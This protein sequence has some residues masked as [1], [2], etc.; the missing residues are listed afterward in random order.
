MNSYIAFGLKIGTP[1][2]LCLNL[3]A[4]T[5]SLYTRGNLYVHWGLG[6]S[7]PNPNFEALPEKLGRVQ[8]GYLQKGLGVFV[9]WVGRFWLK[10]K[11]NLYIEPLPNC[12][13]TQVALYL[14]G[15]VLV[16]RLRLEPILSFHGSAVQ[17]PNGVL[18]ILGNQGAGKS[19]TATALAQAG[20]PLLC[21]DVIPL[22]SESSPPMVLPGIARPKL[23][24][25][26]YE[27]LV[28]DPSKAQHLWD[29]ID[30]Y[31]VSVNSTFEPGSLDR[32]VILEL[33]AK[34]DQPQ[35]VS[36]TGLA[37]L[38]ALQPHLQTL[39]GLDKP[40]LQLQSLMK[41]GG[42]IQVDRLIRPKGVESLST[43]TQLLENVLMEFEKTVDRR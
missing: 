3:P 34:V 39:G 37:K 7:L 6:D 16:F 15:L 24:P 32:I 21:D 36:L 31:Q 23:L 19:T 38:Q 13:L 1:E 10:D 33:G 26:A 14:V 42:Q 30:K 11:E 22:L 8:Y 35:F 28:G 2:N 41:L 27:A 12:D 18:M 4:F 20:F 40:D 25:D 5:D 17:G 29:G 43:V 9:P